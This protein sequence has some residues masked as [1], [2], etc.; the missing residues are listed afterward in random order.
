MRLLEQG[1]VEEHAN[2]D[3]KSGDDHCLPDRHHPR[4]RIEDQQHGAPQGEGDM[5]KDGGREDHHSQFAPR[6]AAEPPDRGRHRASAGALHERHQDPGT[7]HGEQPGLEREAG[8]GIEDLAM[9]VHRRLGECVAQP[10]GNPKGESVDALTEATLQGEQQGGLE[11]LGGNG[12]GETS[13]ENL[14][15]AG[16]DAVLIRVNEMVRGQGQCHSYHSPPDQAAG[17]H[18]QGFVPVHLRLIQ[19]EE[20]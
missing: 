8:G 14:A 15:Q 2:A 18:R 6:T 1:V 9:E 20:E 17:K 5:G 12:D 3:Q 19:V 7:H 10:C 13:E 11:D 4:R 16:D